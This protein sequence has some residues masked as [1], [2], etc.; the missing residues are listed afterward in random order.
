MALTN[1][2]ERKLVYLRAYEGERGVAY[3]L[4]AVGVF[5]TTTA[6]LFL[7]DQPAYLEMGWR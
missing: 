1:W 2:A 5:A 6:A 4:G 3:L 7:I